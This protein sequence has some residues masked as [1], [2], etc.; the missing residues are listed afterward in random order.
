MTCWHDGPV[1]STPSAADVRRAIADLVGSREGSVC[2]S[3]VA[4][5]LESQSWRDLMPVVREAADA[6][7]ADGELRVTQ[8]DDEVSASRATGPVR[9]RRP[10][11]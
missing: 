3:E 1:S 10:R 5:A 11:T 8:G 9:L 7:V 2:P 6:M 4:R